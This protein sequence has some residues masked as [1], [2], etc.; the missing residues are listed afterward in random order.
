M[1]QEWEK[2]AQKEKTSCGKAGRERATAARKIKAK[3]SFWQRTEPPLKQTAGEEL[4]VSFS[5]ETAERKN[6]CY[7]LHSEASP[8][9]DLWNTDM[10]GKKKTKNETGCV[11]QP[12]RKSREISLFFFL[13][14]H[15]KCQR[16]RLLITEMN[17]KMNTVA[18]TEGDRRSHW[19]QI[20]QSIVGCSSINKQEWPLWYCNK[21]EHSVLFLRQWKQVV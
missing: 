17:R 6:S 1:K 4:S 13:L 16:L 3:R 7:V 10:R 2:K 21:C 18:Q 8:N 15:I 12:M 19:I 9:R 14:Q 5:T 11:G 20:A